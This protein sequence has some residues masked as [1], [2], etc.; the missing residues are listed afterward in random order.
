MIKTKKKYEMPFAEITYF[1][2]E[3]FMSG[4][5]SGQHDTFPAESG[6]YDYGEDEEP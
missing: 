5:W 4:M 2:A 3:A 1:N 6:T